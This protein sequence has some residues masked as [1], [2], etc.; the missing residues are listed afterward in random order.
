[1]SLKALQEQRLVK[2]GLVKFFEKNEAAYKTLAQDS[3]NYT[4]KILKPTGIQVRV[5]DVAGHLKAAI[6]V[7]KAFNDERVAKR[8]TQ[9]Y[10]VD[11]FTNYVLDRL[12]KGIV[13]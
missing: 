9:N 11:F 5:D 3:Y 13:P 12:W 1:M 8:C 10:W 2:A 7:D 4:A 6:E